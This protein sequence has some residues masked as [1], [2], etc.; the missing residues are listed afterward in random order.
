[1]FPKRNDNIVIYAH[2]APPHPSASATRML[3]VAK[4]LRARGL[5]VIILTTMPGPSMLAD[6][7]SVVR[8]RGRA[9]LFLWLVRN[10]PK[11]L[12]VTTPPATPAAEVAVLG[13]LLGARVIADIRDP[14][15]SE[16]IT[17]GDFSPGFKARMKGGLEWL[18]LRV[19][20]A[21]SVVSE[22]LRDRMQELTKTRLSR[23]A[24]AQNGA[25]EETFFIDDRARA[26]VRTELNIS[27][28][29][30]FVYAG[31]L[32]G[33][34]LHKVLR[35]MKPALEEGAVLLFVAIIDEYSAPIAQQLAQD[36]GDMGI[37]DRVRWIS[38]QSL[39][40]VARYLN[41][42]DVGINPLPQSR[43]YCLPVKTFEYMAC[44]VF[45]LA[46]GGK[47]ALSAVLRQEE[48]L[49]SIVYDWAEFGVQARRCV[50]DIAK[51]RHGRHQRARRALN[52][53]RAEA[54]ER[55]TELLLD[56]AR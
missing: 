18:L 19:A 21:H 17:N 54:N 39:E 53:S 30:L 50:T 5:R 47:G 40:S 41:A 6:G 8:P 20:N 29:P 14:Y 22:A 3:S 4:Y 32:G 34:E 37:S 45:N 38:N 16:A 35:A 52:F 33:K 28:E 26:L 23:A 46:Y 55:L 1:M 49:G 27:D 24:I 36:A 10:A 48:V 12:L 25:D 42:S 43:T 51:I 9:R 11:I 15:V 56:K 13:R 2:Y 31:I 44:G 7:I